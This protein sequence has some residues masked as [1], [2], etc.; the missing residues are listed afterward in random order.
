MKR[1]FYYF[2]PL[3][4]W[5]TGCLADKI[6]ID[7]PSSTT[8]ETDDSSQTV[9]PGSDPVDET[10]D[11]AKADDIID[12]TTFDRTVSIVFSASGSAE[13]SGAA[14]DISVSVNGNDVTIT[15]NGTETVLYDLSGTTADGFFKLYSAKKQAIRLNGVSITNKNGAAL[16]NQSKKRTFIIVEGT[17]TLADGASY[18]D[19]PSGEDEKAALFS[20]GQLVFSGSGSLTVTAKGKAGI[21]SDDYIHFMASPTVKVS[22]SAG[23]AVRGKDYILVS[24]G[25]IEAST[26]ADMKKGFSSDSLVRFEG[27]VTTITVS[28]GSAKD[29]DGTYT[30]SAGIKAD[31]CFEM[32]GGSVTITNSGQGGKGIKVGSTPDVTVT[33]SNYST[34]AIGTS[35]VSGGTLTVTTT[36]ANYTTGDISSKGIKVGWAIK[37]G[38][39]TYSFYSGDLQFLGGVVNVNS[40]YAEAIECKR[41]L[42]VNGGEVCAVS[43]GDDAVN[44]AGDFRVTSG[45][46]CGISSANDGLD[47]NGNFYIEGGL[48][49]A[50]GKTTPELGIDANS[51]GGFCLTLS[52]GTLIAIGGLE[53]GSR[54][55]Q[56]CYSASSWS[57]NTWYGLTVGSDTY[58]FKTP[59]SGGSGLVVSAA[60]TPT[61]QSG[62]TVSGGTSIFGGYGN[63]GGVSGGSSVS[64]STYSGGGGMGPGGGMGGFG[65]GGHR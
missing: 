29:D 35:Y 45:Y 9:S 11:T 7:G 34:Y 24:D 2:I 60:S 3:A 31:R 25:T 40:K 15:N 52:G 27:G 33:Q 42:T 36:G 47:A 19:T 13:V 32:T 61:L 48:V 57:K 1:A 16:N 49:Y 54:L 5:A 62:V 17:N 39:H 30:G 14:S 41:H 55:N 56:S 28:G 58:A 37:S 63:I 21:T 4:L 26:S 22:S 64:L 6:E 10:S 43:S 23:H 38:Q 20:E 12:G 46:I 18:S 44:S 65:G 59:A 8:T 51:E 53:N 50:V